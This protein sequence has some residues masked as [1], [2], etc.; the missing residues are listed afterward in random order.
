LITFLSVRLVLVLIRR[1][2]LV[3]SCDELCLAEEIKALLHLELPQHK[4]I[5]LRLLPTEKKLGFEF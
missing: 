3:N 2:L 1:F 5:E 4:I